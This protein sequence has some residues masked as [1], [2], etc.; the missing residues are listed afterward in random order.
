[1][2]P[3]PF[4][5]EPSIDV[6]RLLA[7]QGADGLADLM[8]L[9]AGYVPQPRPLTDFVEAVSCGRPLLCMGLPGCGKTAFGKAT[10]YTAT[11]LDGQLYASV[12]YLRQV[13]VG[14]QPTAMI[15]AAT[16]NNSVYGLDATTGAVLWKQNLGPPVPLAMLPRTILMDPRA[17]PRVPLPNNTIPASAIDPTSARMVALYPQPNLSGTI[18]NVLYNPVQTNRVDQFNIRSDYRTDKSAI[19]G[20]FSYEDPDTFNPGNLPEPAV[21]AGPGRPGRVVVPG[22]FQGK[23]AEVVAEVIE[24]TLSSPNTIW[25]LAAGGI[26]YGYKSFYG[27][28]QTRQ[29]YHLTL[30]QSLYFQNLDNNAGVLFRLLDEAEEQECRESLLAYYFLWRRAGDTGWPAERLEA[31]GECLTVEALPPPAGTHSM[32]TAGTEPRLRPVTAP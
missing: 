14:G 26:G 25:A 30:T 22:G 27:Y 5:N 24:R 15:V 20:R 31:A 1:M 32:I 3:K 17:N 4:P 9:R 16:E 11:V 29:R 10:G 23:E 6:R 2:L 12:L 7:E 19:F 21:G 18:N 28:Q 13:M 8:R